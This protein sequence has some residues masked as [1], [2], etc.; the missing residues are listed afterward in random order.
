MASEA[1]LI[2]TE[3][4]R[5]DRR[6]PHY[7]A[8]ALAAFLHAGAAWAFL[9]AS[10]S[11]VGSDETPVV[12]EI[13]SLAEPEPPQ[14]ARLPA[15][16]QQKV[17]PAPKPKPAPVQTAAPSPES[18]ISVAPASEPTSAPAVAVASE[19]K[20]A[21][22]PVARTPEP[23][24][25]PDIKAAYLDNPKPYY[26]ES[27]RRRGLEGV[28]VLLV[29]IDAEGR[30]ASVE[31]KQGSGHAALDRAARETVQSWRFRPATRAGHAVSAQVE[32]PIRFGLRES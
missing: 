26:P 28:V 1:F 7:A 23:F 3:Q 30:A 9:H 31:I 16:E 29:E 12:V 8:L 19:Q 5:R 2:A 21:A 32:V 10:F 15:P 11:G 24:V 25:P 17:T 27:A 18:V 4:D 13:I 14:P 20:L 22:A 6:L